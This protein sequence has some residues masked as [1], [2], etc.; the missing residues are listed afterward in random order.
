M[1]REPTTHREPPAS[2]QRSRNIES[3]LDPSAQSQGQVQV[4]GLFRAFHSPPLSTPTLRACKH[5]EQH[6]NSTQTLHSTGNHAVQ[7]HCSRSCWCSQVS[8][9]HPA[10]ALVLFRVFPPDFHL[11]PFFL[12]TTKTLRHSQ[13]G[14]LAAASSGKTPHASARVDH[15]PLAC[16]QS[17]RPSHRGTAQCVSAGPVSS[18]ANASERCVLKLLY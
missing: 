14:V 2:F 18:A 8:T 13:N 17:T 12:S 6:S 5:Q 16:L 9:L 7:T 11:F 15:T 3:R 1:L 10:S 4:Q